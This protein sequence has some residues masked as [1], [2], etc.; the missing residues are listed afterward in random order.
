MSKGKVKRG[1][2]TQ[3]IRTPQKEVVGSGVFTY[4]LREYQIIGLQYDAT[5]VFMNRL[6]AKMEGAEYKVQFKAGVFQKP[7]VLHLDIRVEVM[8]PMPDGEKRE[9]GMMLTRSEYF[10]QS[11]DNNLVTDEGIRIP[12]DTFIRMQLESFAATRGS[13][14]AVYGMLALTLPPLPLMKLQTATSDFI[15][16]KY[17]PEDATILLPSVQEDPG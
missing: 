8:L 11:T 12:R 9:V 16:V 17:Q 6:N 5:V 3:H 2:G 7:S 1:K 10:I 14:R 15:L 4:R 13:M